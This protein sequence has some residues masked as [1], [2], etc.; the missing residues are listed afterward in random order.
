MVKWGSA[1]K[2]STLVNASSM[3]I[4]VSAAESA[5]LSNLYRLEEVIERSPSSVIHRAV[6]KVTH[7]EYA[8][9]T[10][11]LSK[12]AKSTGL[13]RSEVER[14]LELCATVKHPH[15]CELCDV[16]AGDNYIHL[17]FEFLEGADICFEIVKRAGN[18]FVYSEA[19]ISKGQI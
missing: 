18:G 4:N 13:G 11:D 10:V 16:I 2:S 6:H 12:Y 14:E 3:P 1:G 9:K 15:I 8:I 5:V 7:K 17:V 19:V